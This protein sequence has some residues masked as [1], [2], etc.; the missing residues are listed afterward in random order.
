MTAKDLLKL[1][2]SAPIA[3][4]SSGA[5]YVA[6]TTDSDE[7]SKKIEQLEE[8]L[9]KLQ[10]QNKGYVYMLQKAENEIVLLKS[11]GVK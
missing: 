7:N 4:A 11:K 10:E 2:A 8:R 9:E 5:A 3:V 6:A 1:A